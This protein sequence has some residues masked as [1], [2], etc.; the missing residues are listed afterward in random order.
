MG[1]T[2]LT[3]FQ[4]ISKPVTKFWVNRFIWE[5]ILGGKNE[6]GGDFRHSWE[7]NLSPLLGWLPLWEIGT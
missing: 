4:R 1:I 3:V 7:P 6:S 2:E 5:M